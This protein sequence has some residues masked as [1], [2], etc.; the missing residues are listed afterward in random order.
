MNPRTIRLT[1]LVLV[2]IFSLSAFVAWD[3]VAN[4]SVTDSLTYDDDTMNDC[5]LR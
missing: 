2:L 4:R 1:A 5:L 3:A